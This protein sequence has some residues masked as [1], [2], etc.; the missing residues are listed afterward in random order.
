MSE[1]N[2]AATLLSAITYNC[3][4]QASS[5][6]WEQWVA[7]TLDSEL[8][9]SLFLAAAA[10]KNLEA[11]K[12]LDQIKPAAVPEAIFGSVLADAVEHR[13]TE[14]LRVL[15][16]HS[17]MAAATTSTG[18]LV[19]SLLQASMDEK[20]TAGVE[21]LLLSK[22]VVQHLGSLP[23]VQQL[24][25][26]HIAELLAFITRATSQRVNEV[27]AE[28]GALPAGASA[29]TISHEYEACVQSIEYAR[30]QQQQQQQQQQG[31]QQQQQAPAL[32]SDEAAQLLRG[33]LQGYRQSSSNTLAS[34]QQLC[35][36]QVIQEA[37]DAKP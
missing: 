35:S 15:C 23:G 26:D 3:R 29:E 34:L 30:G 24:S 6:A 28:P 36:M 8:A 33:A 32:T 21:H 4:Q 25:S 9:A 18:Q 22:A 16:K 11:L 7:E 31:Q 1:R 27:L 5:T 13:Q 19:V 20:Y 37:A 10:R 17:G 2:Q 14:L 12:I